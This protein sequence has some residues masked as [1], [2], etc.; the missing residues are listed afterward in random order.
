MSAEVLT[1]LRA[2]RVLLD[3]PASLCK[4]AQARDRQGNAVPWS[5]S[6]ACSWCLV[7]AA[8]KVADGDCEVSDNTLRVLQREHGD[9]LMGWNDAPHR[10]HAEVLDL[11]DRAIAKEESRE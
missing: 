1:E 7:F 5:D 3:E 10:T 2:M 9:Y 8:I 4:K 6:D 11:L